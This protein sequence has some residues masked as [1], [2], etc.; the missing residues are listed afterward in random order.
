MQRIRGFSGVGVVHKL[1]FYLAYLLTYLLKK[2]EIV[3][4]RCTR[5]ISR[6]R[7][8]HLLH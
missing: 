6:R 8:A 1:T 2:L 5:H 4:L 3:S 7:R